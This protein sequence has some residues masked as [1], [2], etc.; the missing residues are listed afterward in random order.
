MVS[1]SPAVPAA[2]ATA[3][4]AT[5]RYGDGPAA[6]AHGGWP[7]RPGSA[8]SMTDGPSTATANVRAMLAALRASPS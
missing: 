5:T 6:K 1:P 8:G 3:A 4:M 7:G 2:S